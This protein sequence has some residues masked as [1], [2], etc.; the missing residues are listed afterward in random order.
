MKL[1]TKLVISSS[2]LIAITAGLAGSIA[3]M[4]SREI[5]IS[6]IEKNLNHIK[7]EILST[8]GDPLSSALLAVS[9]YE[10]S[11]AFMEADGQLSVLQDSAGEEISATDISVSIELGGGEQ[12]KI[13]QDT[14]QIQGTFNQAVPLIIL[15]TLLLVV[16][17]T[18]LIQLLL[19]RDLAQIRNLISDALKI[20]EGR[21]ANVSSGNSSLEL[22]QLN[23]ALQKMLNKLNDSKRQINDFLA[24]ASHEL[25]TPLTVIRGYLDLLRDSSLDQTQSRAVSR[26]L[27]EALRMQ[28]LISEMLALAELGSTSELRI[29]EVNFSQI[30]SQAIEDLRELDPDREVSTDFKSDLQILGDSALLK[31]LVGNL[32]SN[33]RSHTLETDSCQISTGAR[34]GYLWLKVED[35]GP[36]ADWLPLEPS[37]IEPQRF[38]AGRNRSAK[39]SGLG[40]SIMQRIVDLHEGELLFFRSGAGGFGAEIRFKAIRQGLTTP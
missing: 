15:T 24:D 33:L 2:L 21:A 35:S 40:I 7:D 27:D 11:M 4:V 10:V 23:S 22:R 39:G 31:Q 34:E 30:L 32:I 1:R 28:H 6:S 16:L 29:E 12:I 25:K 3:L 14:N 5:S 38:F 9:S 26:S 8:P 20:S 18:V 37:K 13:W 17:A 19:R 36:G